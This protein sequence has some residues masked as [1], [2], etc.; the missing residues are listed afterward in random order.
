MFVPPSYR[1]SSRQL[2][3]QPC[4]D[5]NHAILDPSSSGPTST[6]R[7]ANRPSHRTHSASSDIGTTKTKTNRRPATNSPLPTTNVNFF[8]HYKQA[9]LEKNWVNTTR[10]TTTY[11]GAIDTTSAAA[12]N[13]SSLQTPAAIPAD[14]VMDTTK[15]AS[16]DFNEKERS[17]IRSWKARFA[18]LIA[19]REARPKALTSHQYQTFGP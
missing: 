18:A 9:G 16:E 10:A 11:Q 6:A 15:D 1:N 4:I 13:F 12:T 5:D 7:R 19:A 2:S 17:N 3:S 14:R 8:I